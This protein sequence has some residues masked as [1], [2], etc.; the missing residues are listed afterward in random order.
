MPVPPRGY[1][2]KARTG[3]RVVRPPLLE[4][5]A[6]SRPEPT[7]PLTPTLPAP[8]SVAPTEEAARYEALHQQLLAEMPALSVPATLRKPH[9]L[10]TSW[11][12]D[13]ARD[14]QRWSGLHARPAK[15][16]YATPFARR[17]LRF[18]NTLF[19]ALEQRGF[20][21]THDPQHR[22]DCQATLEGNTVRFAAYERIRQVR[23]PL[24]DEERAIRPGQKYTQESFATGELILALESSL[25]RGLTRSWSNQADQPIETEINQILAGILVATSYENE[26]AKIRAAAE[27]VRWEAQKQKWERGRQEK[28][29]QDRRAALLKIVKDWRD[30]GE[31][32]AFVE[33]LKKAVNDGEFRPNAEVFEPWLDWAMERAKH[34]DPILSG[35]TFS[36][37][38]LPKHEHETE[39]T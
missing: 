17:R 9:P 37:D 23:R 11:L 14:R 22:F 34:L 16:K 31:I 26:Q 35:W 33:A 30:A 7:I 8:A 25:P 21:I 18:L 6:P 36:K 4:I 28:L 15:S 19:H 20:K 3:K 24:T 39:S 1:W 2:A 27:Q 29:E 13:D 12:E 10:I 32:R 38:L 5:D